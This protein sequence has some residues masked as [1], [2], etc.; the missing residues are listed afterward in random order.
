MAVV[1]PQGG[2]QNKPERPA[3]W[4]VE[5]YVAGGPLPV[6]AVPEIPPFHAAAGGP[7]VPASTGVYPLHDTDWVLS[8]RVTGLA[9]SVITDAEYEE[10][11]S[12]G[13]PPLP[14]TEQ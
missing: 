2:Q 13:G 5:Q 12:G 6:G 4:Y 8:S 7:Y 1:P 3:A 10:R 11:F 14:E 9:H